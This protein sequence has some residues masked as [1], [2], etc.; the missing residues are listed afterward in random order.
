MIRQVMLN[1]HEGR[2]DSLGVFT[3]ADSLNGN[4]EVGT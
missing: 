2:A 3:S 1:L 4:F